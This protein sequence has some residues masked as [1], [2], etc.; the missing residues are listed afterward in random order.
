MDAVAF[1]LP[2]GSAT[3]AIATFGLAIVSRKMRFALVG[4]SLA[5]F[6]VVVVVAPRLAQPSPPPIASFRLVSANTFLGNE[7]TLTAART[8]AGEQPDVLVAVET[9][10]PMRVALRLSLPADH[11]AA[12]L[13]NQIVFARWP[14]SEPLP[15]PGVSQATGMR[16]EVVRPDLPFVLYAVHLPNPLSGTSF[17]AH[18]TTIERL[19][20]SAQ[21][22]HLPVILAGD[23]NMTDRSTS[24][25]ALDD[26]MRD[27][28]RSSFAATTYDRWQWALLQLRI[29][30]VFVSDQ[31]C[32]MDGSTFTVRGSDH[33]ALEVD[34]GACPS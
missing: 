1:A 28:M 18:A 6:T 14:V 8:L 17:S 23:F 4:L 26:A 3:L 9:S 15:I 25:R 27:A 10:Q 13:G 20:Q 33:D 30:H 19:L 16:V 11:W 32:D 31:L 29:D 2:L 12:Q 21:G 22:E 7:W 5:V 34:L 24:Y